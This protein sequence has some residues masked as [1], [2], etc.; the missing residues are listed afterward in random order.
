MLISILGLDSPIDKSAGVMFRQLMYERD[1]D[2]VL[3]LVSKLL[4]RFSYK[5][6]RHLLLWDDVLST[7]LNSFLDQCMR[8][9]CKYCGFSRAKNTTRQFEHVQQCNEFLNSNEGQQAVADGLLTM[10][11]P[12][13]PQGNASGGKGDIFRGRA[14]NPTFNRPGGKASNLAA[15]RPAPPPKPSPSLVNHLLTKNRTALEQATQL[16][17][18]SHAGCGTLSSAALQQWLAQQGHMSRVLCTFIGS[19]IGKIRLSDT[20]NPS[21]DTSWRALDLLVSAVNNAKRELEFLRTTHFKYYL[22]HEAESPKPA[23]KGFIDLF[24]SVS[25]PPSSLLEGLVVLWAV[26]Y[27]SS[28][29]WMTLITLL[30]RNSSTASRGNT[31]PTSSSQLRH[32]RHPTPSHLTSS[33]AN[34]ICPIPTASHR[35]PGTRTTPIPPLSTRRSSRT[36]RPPASLSLLTRA[37]PSSMSS[38]MRR[39]PVTAPS[40]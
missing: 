1:P 20:Q 10:Q 12:P 16:Q 15:A 35:P 23:T 24:A 34:T 27:V 31:P 4:V 39:Q 9:R 8:T 29:P 5:L 30:N 14:P 25:S 26:E 38:P 33:P 36:G 6:A 21:N 28:L 40:S 32:P 2:A 17:F 3:P 22:Q 37:S 11:P 7:D 19:L 18:F 13:E